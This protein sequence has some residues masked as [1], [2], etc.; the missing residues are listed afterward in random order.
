MD[1]S[2]GDT[3]VGPEVDTRSSP[4]ASMLPSFLPS[5][6]TIAAALLAVCVPGVWLAR[7]TGERMA[8]HTTGAP[9]SPGRGLE[10]ETD[11]ARAAFVAGDTRGAAASLRRA[12]RLLATVTRPEDAGLAGPALTAS[13]A[14]LT[15]LAVA[16]EAGTVR[17]VRTLD[18]VVARARLADARKHY[19]RVM[20]LIRNLHNA[21]AGIELLWA[22]DHLGRVMRD[23]APD[24]GTD[25]AAVLSDARAAALRL[26]R[27]GSGVPVSTGVVLERL[28]D[29]IGRAAARTVQG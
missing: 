21:E 17:R 12:A 22:V 15:A 8:V 3:E 26:T 27:P 28:G 29:E 18:D 13:A 14:E 11:L 20:P 4:E 1:G 6:R 25:T 16:V 24:G 19:A 7:A 5:S 10:G 2:H 23:A 9:V